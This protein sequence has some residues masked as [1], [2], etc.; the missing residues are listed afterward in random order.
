MKPEAKSSWT[1]VQEWFDSRTGDEKPAT[2]VSGPDRV[3]WARVLP[4]VLM[5]VACFAVIW[6]GFSP[7]AIGVAIALYLVR[8]IAITGF[9]HRYFSH[10]SF[11]TGRIFQFV[12][13][14]IGAMAVQRGALWW[15]AHHRHHHRHSDLEEDLHSRKHHGFLWS[16]VGWF[17]S[18]R[19]FRTRS[20]AIQDFERF[21]ELVFLDRYDTLVPIVFAFLLLGL[22]SLLGAVAPGLGTNGPQMLVW[23]FFISTVVLHH[24]TF[25]INSLAHDFGRRRYNTADNSRNSLVLAL[26][27]LGEGWHN[28]HHHYP[29]AA[30]QGF[31]WW[32]IDITWYVLKGLALIGLIWDLKGV[33][34]ETRSATARSE[35]ASA[36]GGDA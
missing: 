34:N 11:K 20:S 1:I 31:F 33:P 8:M 36:E 10:R 30:R 25:T 15:A 35:L 14:L 5:H 27:T 21:P 9:Y 3:E 12:M 23:G 13:A 16:H 32:E 7:A 6:T 17:T 18:K 4:F 28:N 29:H 24:A 22:G 26:L 2:P 19:N